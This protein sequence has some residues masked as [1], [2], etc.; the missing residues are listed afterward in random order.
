MSRIVKVD[1][2][3]NITVPASTVKIS[4]HV[5]AER[6]DEAIDKALSMLADKHGFGPD[7][8]LQIVATWADAKTPALVV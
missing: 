2:A 3:F 8:L 7:D 4:F 1:L 6:L 5:E